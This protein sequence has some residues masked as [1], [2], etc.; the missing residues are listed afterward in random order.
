[1]IT[2]FMQFGCKISWSIRFDR[3][4]R[5]VS[6]Q[7]STIIYF[8]LLLPIYNLWS[9]SRYFWKFHFVSTIVTLKVSIISILFNTRYCRYVFP[10]IMMTSRIK[11]IY[12]ISSKLK[13]SSRKKKKEKS[14]IYNTDVTL[15]QYLASY[16]WLKGI[17]IFNMFYVLKFSLSERNC[18]FF[19]FVIL[20]YI[21]NAGNT[22]G[23]AGFE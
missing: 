16:N 23:R 8:T 10:M 22:F 4:V 3:T 21:F 17:L 13:W 14:T 1:M 12:I 19:S 18:T 5:I 11:L 15:W 7:C 6:N 2:Y 9:H 20:F